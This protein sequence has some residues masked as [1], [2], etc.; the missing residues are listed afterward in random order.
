M[1]AECADPCRSTDGI[2]LATQRT[3]Q[4]EEGH[5]DDLLVSLIQLKE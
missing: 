1:P 4:A 5:R 3:Y 2:G